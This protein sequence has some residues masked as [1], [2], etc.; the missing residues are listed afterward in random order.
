METSNEQVDSIDSKVE[1]TLETTSSQFIEDKNQ[2][3]ANI[4]KDIKTESSIICYDN[5]INN[6]PYNTCNDRRNKCD[7]LENEDANIVIKDKINADVTGF[8][9][10]TNQ[11]K[12]L[13]APDYDEKCVVSPPTKCQAYCP[14]DSI[15]REDSPKNNFVE[16]RK[17]EKIPTEEIV[18]ELPVQ[19]EK[20]SKTAA[21][22]ISQQNYENTLRC[23][24]Q[25]F[26][27]EVIEKNVDFQHD[28]PEDS[29]DSNIVKNRAEEQENKIVAEVENTD[30]DKV[31]NFGLNQ[32]SLQKGIIN[33][34]T[35]NI[36][37]NEDDS[38]QSI[39]T[40][41]SNAKQTLLP[42]N[43]NVDY[44][45][46]KPLT[47][48]K[49]AKDGDLIDINE[50]NSQNCSRI[51]IL[52]NNHNEDENRI[53]LDYEGSNL[54]TNEESNER[55]C[56]ENKGI[57]IYNDER[58]QPL[59][60]VSIQDNIKY[61]EINQEVMENTQSNEVLLTN[62]KETSL[63]SK[64]CIQENKV[65]TP[66]KLNGD[67]KITAVPIWDSQI[68]NS[69]ELDK[70]LEAKRP[71]INDKEQLKVVELEDFEKFNS[72]P[73]MSYAFE[74]KVDYG[75]DL[76]IDNKLDKTGVSNHSMSAESPQSKVN[77]DDENS[78]CSSLASI[79]SNS[80]TTSS[81]HQLVI[82]QPMDESEAG[83]SAAS[84]GYCQINSL[85]QLHDKS[86]KV[87]TLKPS[88]KR[89]LST[90]NENGSSPLLKQPHIDI[91]LN[92]N[93]NSRYFCD[94]DQTE[95]MSE[96]ITEERKSVQ[97]S[98]ITH[99]VDAKH[100]PLK[101]LLLQH[102]QKTYSPPEPTEKL[103]DYPAPLPRFTQQL[104]TISF[105]DIS[106]KF[107][108]TILNPNGNI[109][110]A[111]KYLC[112]KC[113][114]GSF[115]SF[116]ALNE[117]QREC[118]ADTRLLPARLNENASLLPLS[119]APEL[120]T[121]PSSASPDAT[122]DMA[123]R[124]AEIQTPISS[125]I[126]PFVPD[127]ATQ[128]KRYY[129]CSSCNTFHENWNLFLH[130]RDKHQRHMCLYCIRFFP[131]AEKLSVHLEIK[132]DLEQNHFNSEE[133]LRKSVSMVGGTPS[134][135]RFLMCCTCQHL[136]EETQPF[137]DHNCAEFMKPCTLCGQKGRHSNQCKAHPDA[138]R[139]SKS[140]KRLKKSISEATQSDPSR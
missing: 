33:Q 130:I 87:N 134:E 112:F 10:S 93:E 124:N 46:E 67:H 103:T 48:R 101:S 16:T 123:A 89:K 14:H 90:S 81:S 32:E 73:C 85:I 128:K 42:G 60:N 125:F 35:E 19:E 59:E 138:K 80:T 30:V 11:Q 12:D 102:L 106:P 121:P 131:T 1:S 58:E 78:H 100:A 88:L 108:A 17:E 62:E 110:T 79:E 115:V 99:K 113:K 28:D 2:Q 66:L 119:L 132:H 53:K 75:G 44:S 140:K 24:K 51:E 133:A 8:G 95:A 27:S 70:Q 57:K 111:T 52:K 114:V 64:S 94:K 77:C 55:I 50:D 41:E 76:D 105:D 116:A 65:Q 36:A 4:I 136:F 43:P 104:D 21:A 83:M 68:D 7:L 63:D 122:V 34:A 91:Q 3:D 40:S 61:L 26:I 13:N 72:E 96:L 135:S 20:D 71:E 49:S 117:H 54:T 39:A 6:T 23:Q 38:F 129:K 56:K 29:T 5:D 15:E 18:H 139:T 47:N 118:L 109:S 45:V 31:N 107:P 25:D 74:N 9:T 37:T 92:D 97:F 22:E 69:T 86:E 82:D 126:P 137:S 98:D 120:A 84:T 127:A